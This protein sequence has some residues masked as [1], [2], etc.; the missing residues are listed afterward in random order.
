MTDDQIRDAVRKAI[1]RFKA[2]DPPL[3]FCSVHERSTAFRLA[4]HLE[5]LF[6]D[7]W[8]VDSEYDRT[9]KN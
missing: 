5:P 8:N 2:E 6:S 4:I 3:E 1:E 9:V 7:Q